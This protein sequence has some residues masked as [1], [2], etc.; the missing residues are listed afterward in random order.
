MKPMIVVA[1]GAVTPAG[2]TAP[3]SAFALR[4]TATAVREAPLVDGAGEPVTMGLVPTIDPRLAGPGRLGELAFKAFAEAARDVGA[5]SRELRAAV[6]LLAAEDLDPR[7][8]GGRDPAAYLATEL[9]AQA[10]PFF[11]Q[12]S[13]E[14]APRGPAGAAGALSDLTDALAAG[15]IDV[16]IL[17]GVHSDHDPRRVAE[18]DLAGRLFTPRN[19]DAILPGEA[20]AFVALMRPDVARRHRLAARARVVSLGTGRERARHDNDES[21]FAAHGL[22]AAMRE[23]LGPH[24]SP[25]GGAGGVGW[26]VSDANLE[27]HRLE[28]H[29]AAAIRLTRA[30]V[31]PSVV[32]SPAQRLGRLGAAAIPFAIAMVAEAHRRGF[33]HHPNTLCLAGN[34][35]GERAAILLGAPAA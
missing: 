24:A 29:T 27:P 5:A 12:V 31:P 32:E 30:F 9:E 10:R 7:S 14:V 4:T 19:L 1:A 20:A 6:V 15:S 23:A 35:G 13:V 25:E 22:T 8:P 16:A 11:T 21:S 18:L 26:V 2:L 33:A 17:G 34:D 3:E 28:E